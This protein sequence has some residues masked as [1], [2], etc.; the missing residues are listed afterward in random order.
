MHMG[1]KNQHL[2]LFM[3]LH[4]KSNSNTVTTTIIEVFSE[5]HTEK[6]LLLFHTIEKINEHTSN[7]QPDD[8]IE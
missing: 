1:V 3:I 7:Q 4:P 2:I 6:Q 5:I 8:F